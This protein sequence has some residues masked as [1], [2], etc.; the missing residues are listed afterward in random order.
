[1]IAAAVGIVIITY[2]PLDRF[3]R[4]HYV[5]QRPMARSAL[6]PSEPVA[7]LVSGSQGSLGSTKLV[8]PYQYLPAVLQLAT[9]CSPKAAFRAIV[10]KDA[11]VHV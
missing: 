3:S 7:V 10:H 5:L 4:H 11:D 2:G 9:V 6:L 1:M 8:D